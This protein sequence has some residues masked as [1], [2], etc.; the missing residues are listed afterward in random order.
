MIATPHEFASPS[1]RVRDEYGRERCTCGRPR[2]AHSAE[3]QPQPPAL[4]SL[5]LVPM[6]PVLPQP[7]A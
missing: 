7:P 2:E 6:I 5:P 4:P 3:A 1:I